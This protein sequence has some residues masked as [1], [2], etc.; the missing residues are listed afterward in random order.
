MRIKTHY[1]HRSSFSFSCG[2]SQLPYHTIPQ[3][4]TRDCGLGTSFNLIICKFVNT[5]NGCVNLILVCEFVR[6]CKR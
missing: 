5:F 6:V 2:N 4:K 3:Q 1:H